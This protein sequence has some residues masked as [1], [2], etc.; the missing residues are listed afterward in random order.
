VAGDTLTYGELADIISRVTGRDVLREVWSVEK[1][2]RE[3]GRNPEDG[4]KR[5]RLAFAGEGVWWIK[6][7]TV[8]EE[9][10]MGMVGVEEYA[11][12]VVFAE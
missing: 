1:L 3:V 10:G 8:N 2:K 11:R 4:I 6:E 5:Y 12:S 9:L 7:G